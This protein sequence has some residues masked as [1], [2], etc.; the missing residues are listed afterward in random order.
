MPSPYSSS[1]QS[2]CARLLS[3]LQTQAVGTLLKVILDEALV[4]SE[5]FRRSIHTA[6]AP[7]E[8]L[9]CVRVDNSLYLDNACLDD[10]DLE[11]LTKLF[12]DGALDHVH[13]LQLMCTVGSDVTPLRLFL[14]SLRAV[15]SL[16][17]Q[18]IEAPNWGRMQGLAVCNLFEDSISTGALPQL[19]RLGGSLCSGDRIYGC[20]PGHL[21]GVHRVKRACQKR[22]IRDDLI[23]P[24]VSQG[25]P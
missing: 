3:S 16:S 15:K 22:S 19:E 2:C 17:I 18:C 21:E 23:V 8:H 7:I 9:A 1:R 4:A 10:T 5:L 25:S 24:A 12:W 6:R 13:I 11:K 20:N 14:R